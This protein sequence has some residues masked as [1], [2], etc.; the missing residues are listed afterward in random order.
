MGGL[1]HILPVTAQDDKKRICASS[2]N[3]ARAQKPPGGLSPEARENYGKQ[4]NIK[5]KKL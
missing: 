1:I 5:E 2:G 3:R 4:I